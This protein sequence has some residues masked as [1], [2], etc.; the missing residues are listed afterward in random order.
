MERPPDRRPSA[1]KRGYGAAWERL[2]ARVLAEEPVC[3]ACGIARATDVDH[4]LPRRR[5]GTDARDNLQ[6]L[7][8]SCHSQKTSRSDGGWGRGRVIPVTSG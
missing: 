8:H 4:I 5:G 7:C 3:R 6:A 2:R 1:R